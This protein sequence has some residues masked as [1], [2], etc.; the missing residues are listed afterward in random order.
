MSYQNWT[1]VSN[2]YSP[3]FN[4]HLNL[5]TMTNFV[6]DLTGKTGAWINTEMYIAGSLGQSTDMIRAS[7][8]SAEVMRLMMSINAYYPKADNLLR[9]MARSFSPNCNHENYYTILRERRPEPNL[10]LG[11]TT[12]EP[13]ILRTR[14]NFLNNDNEAFR[15]AIKSEPDIEDLEWIGRRKACWSVLFPIKA[16]LFDHPDMARRYRGLMPFG[17]QVASYYN[18]VVSDNARVPVTTEDVAEGLESPH[19]A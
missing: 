11:I 6:S 7:V 9:Y 16:F 12:L 5:M 10:A 13:K 1:P 18:A 19:V 8:P 15:L 2:I 4:D 14:M 3:S 17:R